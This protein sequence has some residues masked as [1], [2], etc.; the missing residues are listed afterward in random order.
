MN[1]PPITERTALGLSREAFKKK[2]G[3]CVLLFFACPFLL[4]TLYRRVLL[5]VYNKCTYTTSQTV[6]EIKTKIEVMYIPRKYI[7]STH[8]IARTKA[9]KPQPAE[10]PRDF[11]LSQLLDDE[12]TK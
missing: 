1:Y 5:S 7:L 2:N 9:T 8:A 10:T 6:N 4:V 12:D 3:L 11:A